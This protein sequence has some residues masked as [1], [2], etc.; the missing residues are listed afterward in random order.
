MEVFKDAAKSRILP[1]LGWL[2]CSFLFVAIGYVCG[3]GIGELF[4][5]RGWV[6]FPDDMFSGLSILMFPV[7]GSILGVLCMH[8]IRIKIWK[9]QDRQY[10]SDRE[11]WTSKHTAGMIILD[12][13]MWLT[14][15]SL[16]WLLLIKVL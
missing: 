12:E 1:G 3:Y 2:L 13:L 10:R 9:K 15:F 5:S 4:V 16:I 8:L 7:G 6:R 11:G 14:E